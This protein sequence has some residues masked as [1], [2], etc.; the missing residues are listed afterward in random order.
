MCQQHTRGHGCE[1]TRGV[2]GAAQ[3][4]HADRASRRGS[5]PRRRGARSNGPAAV[6]TTRTAEARD[7]AAPSSGLSRSGV[8]EDEDKRREDV[9]RGGRGGQGGGHEGTVCSSMQTPTQ[10]S[11]TKSD[12]RTD[13]QR[14]TTGTSA[15]SRHRDPDIRTM[16]TAAPPDV[17]APVSTY[18]PTAASR[19]T[20]ADNFLQPAFQTEA[21]RTHGGRTGSGRSTPIGGC[22]PRL[23]RRSRF[24]DTL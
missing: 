11:S 19:L 16:E 4:P 18:A 2:R 20:P 5:L 8:A 6:S 1:G 3:R 14:S 13:L 22:A 12:P 10:S 24:S 7:C 9:G 15:P 21:S 23:C 17:R